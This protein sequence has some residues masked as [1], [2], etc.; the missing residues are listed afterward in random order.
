[1]RSVVE[2]IICNENESYLLSISINSLYHFQ[3]NLLI[4]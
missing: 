3:T 2:F 1:M 4:D